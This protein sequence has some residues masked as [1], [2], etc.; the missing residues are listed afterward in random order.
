MSAIQAAGLWT[1]L[2]I[3]LVVILSVRV[4]L[5]R[6]KHR[7]SLGDGGVDQMT[8]LS[9]SFGNAAEYSP[10]F[11]GALI[12]L[13]L[14]GE[15]AT[16]IHLLGAAFFVGRLVHPLGLAMRPPNWARIVGMLLTWL[17]LIAAA[18][19]LVLAAL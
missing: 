10:F 2:L 4:M 15:T 7:V 14:V 17:S 18:V 8:V 13:A 12:L 1:G 16:T 9:R 19:L 5:G 6:Q 3:L 11:I